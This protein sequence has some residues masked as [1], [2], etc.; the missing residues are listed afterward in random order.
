M[1]WSSNTGDL[2]PSSQQGASPARGG[3]VARRGSVIVMGGSSGDGPRCATLLA[4][5]AEGEGGPA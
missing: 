4:D 1:P 3:G 2:G 5:A